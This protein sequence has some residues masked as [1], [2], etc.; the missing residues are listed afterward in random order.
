MDQDQLKQASSRKKQAPTVEEGRPIEWAASGAEAEEKP[1]R[2]N[3]SSARM[4]AGLDPLI[5]SGRGGRG[6]QSRAILRR[7]RDGTWKVIR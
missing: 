1:L 2:G 6:I 3:G 4:Y 5:A 7:R